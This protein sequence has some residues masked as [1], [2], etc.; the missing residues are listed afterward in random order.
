[1]PSFILEN[2]LDKWPLFYW[3]ACSASVVTLTNSM[4]RQG[5]A[6]KTFFRFNLLC[7]Y[8]A[9]FHIVFCKINKVP[10]YAY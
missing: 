6:M 5:P 4:L 10:Y 2:S 7:I 1:M 9:N 3:N 8:A